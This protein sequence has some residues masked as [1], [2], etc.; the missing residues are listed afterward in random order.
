MWTKKKNE[1]S[2]L[3]QRIERRQAT[4]VNDK[5]KP[6]F[7]LDVGIISFDVSEKAIELLW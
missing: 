6:L 4:A 5:Q 2:I 7:C 1:K 3:V